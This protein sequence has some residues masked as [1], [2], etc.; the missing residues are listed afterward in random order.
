M[1]ALPYADP[2]RAPFAK[3]RFE[4][5]SDK[6]D[7]GFAVG[8]VAPDNPTQAALELLPVGAWKQ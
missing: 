4:L 5:S 7:T 6:A 3:V 8:F 2:T 1:Y